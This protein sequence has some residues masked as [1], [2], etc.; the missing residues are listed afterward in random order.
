MLRAFLNL[1]GYDLDLSD[2]ERFELALAVAKGR[3]DVDE[4]EARLRPAVTVL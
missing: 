4:V 2:D 1:N 3:I